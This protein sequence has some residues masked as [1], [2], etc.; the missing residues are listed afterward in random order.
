MK[1]VRIGLMIFAAL[2]ISFILI[3]IPNSRDSFKEPIEAYRVYL[4]G[5]SIGLIES[6]E[7]LEKYIDD[8]QQEIKKKYNVS[9]VYIPNGLDIEKEITYSNNIVTEKHIYEQIKDNQSFAIRGYKITLEVLATT[10]SITEEAKKGETETIYVLDK[11]LFSDAIESTV[12]A[13][14]NK[15][16]YENYKNNTQSEI[17]EYGSKIE[18]VYVANNIKIAKTN[19]SVDNKIFTDA[20]ELKAYLLFGA[21][22]NSRKYLVRKGDT[23]EKIADTNKLSSDEL[24][25]VNSQLKG[26]NTILYEGQEINIGIIDPKITTVEETYTVELQKIKYETEVRYNYDLMAGTVNTIQEGVNGQNKVAKRIKKENGEITEVATISSDVITPVV[27]KIVERGARYGYLI[28]EVGYW[29]WPTKKPYTLSAYMGWRWGRMHNGIDI[30]GTGHGSPIYAANDGTVI[31]A[32]YQGSFGNY[33]TI[34]HNNGYTTLY[35]HMSKLYVKT[36]QSVKAGTVIGA[37]GSTGYS[38]GTHLHFEARY[39]GKLL[40]P[41]LLY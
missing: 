23:I 30:T 8:E 25:V 2:I 33:V 41:L 20:D 10:G 3:F 39:N 36:G 12:I 19:I 31:V 21:T 29:T 16:Q 22:N 15:E 34:D 11:D 4:N 38:T 17:Q 9:T 24:L 13:F 5:K 35:A 1:K 26:E 32:K 6:K 7:K 14:I 28:G 40:N 18:N 27:N 37:M